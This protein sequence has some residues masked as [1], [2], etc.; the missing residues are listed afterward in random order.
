MVDIQR[1]VIVL[2]MINTTSCCCY[3]ERKCGHQKK[4][5]LQYISYRYHNNEHE[6]RTTTTTTINRLPPSLSVTFSFPPIQN[7]IESILYYAYLLW[8]YNEE[9]MVAFNCNHHSGAVDNYTLWH[10][11]YI[12]IISLTRTSINT[13]FYTTE[14]TVGVVKKTHKLTFSHQSQ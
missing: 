14:E 4:Q 3:C 12:G 5:N 13:Y 9:C 7:G 11:N 8:V 6:K 2:T 10:E 1:A